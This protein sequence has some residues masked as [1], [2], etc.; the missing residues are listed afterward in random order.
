MQKK[1]N[2]LTSI[3]ISFNKTGYIG[4]PVIIKTD[5]RLIC[6]SAVAHGKGFETECF[7]GI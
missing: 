2:A 5:N 7:F 4:I 6:L 1:T 3:I